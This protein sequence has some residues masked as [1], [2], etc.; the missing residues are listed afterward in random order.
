MN[1]DEQREFLK[2][3]Y[4]SEEVKKIIE[5]MNGTIAEMKKQKKS[6]TQY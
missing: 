1:D 5:L 3:V 4:S 6:K 2:S